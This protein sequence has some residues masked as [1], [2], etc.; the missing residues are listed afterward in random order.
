MTEDFEN[1]LLELTITNMVSLMI[2]QYFIRN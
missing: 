2:P 1:K